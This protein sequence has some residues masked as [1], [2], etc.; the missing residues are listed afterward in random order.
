MGFL[1]DDHPDQDELYVD[2]FRTT[3]KFVHTSGTLLIGLVRLVHF[4][5][6][7][8]LGDVGSTH[9]DCYFNIYKLATKSPIA[10]GLYAR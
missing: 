5:A 9:E 10:I 6:A 4:P 1:E 3:R 7:K 2:I 8:F